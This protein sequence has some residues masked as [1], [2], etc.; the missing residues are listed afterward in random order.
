MSTIIKLLALSIL[1]LT[2]VTIHGKKCRALVLEGGGDKGAYQA[3]AIRGLFESLPRN[4]SAYDVISGV[5]IGA[6]NGV[7]YALHRPG[8]EDEATNFLRKFKNLQ[9]T[10]FNFL[11]YFIKRIFAKNYYWL[12]S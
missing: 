12:M 1:C 11:T 3:G 4:E 9:S 6:I 2:F 5:S 10:C 7:S 8:D